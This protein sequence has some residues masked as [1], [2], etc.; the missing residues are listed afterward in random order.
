MSVILSRT[1]VF[2]LSCKNYWHY[3]VLL[4][5]HD[6]L[7]GL[8]KNKSHTDINFK[9][10]NP[11]CPLSLHTFWHLVIYRWLQ[12]QLN[13]SVFCLTYNFHLEF[14]DLC[15]V[16]AYNLLGSPVWVDHHGAKV[17][18]IRILIYMW[19][20]NLPGESSVKWLIHTLLGPTL[21]LPG[22]KCLW[23]S[24]RCHSQHQ[25]IFN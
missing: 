3:L 21:W 6:L 12:T 17:G 22:V 10:F 25:N 18:T 20:S 9:K 14:D 4:H 8:P 23:H 2:P 11:F 13:G 19:D 5:E 24:P 15:F 7:S 1:Y 16:F